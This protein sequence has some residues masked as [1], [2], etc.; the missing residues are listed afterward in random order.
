MLFG[1]AALF[2]LGAV[3]GPDAAVES[4]APAAADTRLVETVLSDAAS[5]DYLAKLDAHAPV[6]AQTFRLEA[7]FAIKDGW[8]QDEIGALLM[9]AVFAQF[10]PLASDLQAA[11]TASYDAILAHFGDGM[12]TLKAQKSAWCQGP[13]VAKF[14]T[15]NDDEIVPKL[16]AQFPYGSDGY[17]W[18]LAWGGLFLDAAAEGRRARVRHGRPDWR[19]EVALQQEGVAFGTQKWSLALQ[20]GAFSTSE[21]QSYAMMQDAIGAMDVC[22]IGLAI[23]DVSGRLEADVRGRIWADLMPEIMYGNTPYVLARVNDYFFIG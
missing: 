16:L 17:D 23:P 5:R 22:A 6:A 18:A 2:A 19:D 7:A 10:R 1:V 13:R 14:L 4:P 11:P 15:E 12:A 8:T 20:I 3:F 9:E 21:G